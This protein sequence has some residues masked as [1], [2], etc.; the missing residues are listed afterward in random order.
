M[1]GKTPD[2]SLEQITEWIYGGRI[3]SMPGEIAKQPFGLVTCAERD[4]VVFRCLVKD[5]DH[6]NASHDV[7]TPRRISIWLACQVPVYG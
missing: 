1:A 3:V 6:A 5:C 2:L 7:T 4:G